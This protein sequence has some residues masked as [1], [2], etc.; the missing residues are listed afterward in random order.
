M[1]DV[2][3]SICAFFGHRDSPMVGQIE[4]R[5]NEAVRDLILQNVSEF[6]LGE[7]GSFDSL[8]RLVVK[9]LRKEFDWINLSIFP[10]Y[11]PNNFKFDWMYENDYGLMFP[12]EVAKAPPQVAILC[13]NEYIA[14]NADYIICY[15]TRNYGGAYKAV[16]KARKYGKIII[17]IAE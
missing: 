16:E 5:L 17:N 9:D 8:S 15:I 3:L 11:Y 10:A 1:V 2:V 7:Q 13:R 14:K 12:E 4:T 6:W